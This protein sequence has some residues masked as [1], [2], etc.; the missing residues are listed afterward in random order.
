MKEGSL[1]EITEIPYST[2]T[3][4]IM[5]K[6]AELIKA[7]KIREIADMRDETDLG[8]LKLT[9]DLKRGVDPD[10]LMQKL[11]RMTPLQ[12]SFACNFNILIA[13]MPRV[14]GIGEI[15]ERMDCLA[16]G[17]REAR[18]YFQ[19]QKKRSGCICSRVWSGS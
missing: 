12:D 3:E 19:V 18:L 15:P 8:G 10:K 6:V 5:D 17:L 9:I 14:M 13:G 4:V 2:A 1:I 7:G 11:F 16:H